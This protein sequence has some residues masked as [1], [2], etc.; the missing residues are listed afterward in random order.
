MAE[1]IHKT[2][3]I[4]LFKTQ[5][6]LIMIII[7]VETNNIIENYGIEIPEGYSYVGSDIIPKYNDI[8]KNTIVNYFLNE[9]KVFVDE[10]INDENKKLI[11]PYP[12]VPNH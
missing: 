2:G 10:Y 8:E 9:K 3:K 7:K 5:T 11:Y 4:K 1:K 12:G 6:H